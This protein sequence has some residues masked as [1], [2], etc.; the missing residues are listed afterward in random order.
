MSSI[1]QI[2][3]V[4]NGTKTTKPR[5]LIFKK[6]YRRSENLQDFCRLLPNVR[7]LVIERYH[8]KN[9]VK[10]FFFVKLICVKKIHRIH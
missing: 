9:T 1:S 2:F 7:D 3:C 5:E 8:Y 10:C 4:I 6:F